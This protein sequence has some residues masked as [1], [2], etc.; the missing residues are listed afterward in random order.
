MQDSGWVDERIL[1]W[2]QEREERPICGDVEAPQ[3]LFADTQH[4]SLGV[5]MIGKADHERRPV[6]VLREEVRRHRAALKDLVTVVEKRD[7]VRSLLDGKRL[8]SQLGEAVVAGG[9][10]PGA[11]LSRTLLGPQTRA[12]GDLA[13][14]GY[15]A[16]DPNERPRV[17][18]ALDVL[19]SVHVHIP[20]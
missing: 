3:L 9:V 10:G 13:R 2:A 18:F 14:A 15:A 17:L 11:R 8:G 16:A 5:G 6:L 20:R 1:G 12:P 7:R 4:H 19:V